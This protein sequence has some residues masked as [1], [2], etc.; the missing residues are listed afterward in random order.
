[1]APVSSGLVSWWPGEGNAGDVVGGNSGT[2]SA[3]VIF[4]PGK[5]GQSFSF[6][7]IS[8]SVQVPDAPSLRFTTAVTIEAWIYPRS[9]GGHHQEIVSKWEGGTDQRSYTSKI[10]PDGRFS[11]GISDGGRDD[12]S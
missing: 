9:V 1:C 7:G 3:N 6:D 8:A 5:V 10:A 12:P 2:P 4:V 11:F